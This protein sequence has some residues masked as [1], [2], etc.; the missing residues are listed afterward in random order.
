MMKKEIR[1]NDDSEAPE[2]RF[3]AEKKR[4]RK[5]KA[6]REREIRHFLHDTRIGN[7]VLG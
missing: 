5:E 6:T 4:K 2:K 7:S 3:G 1:T